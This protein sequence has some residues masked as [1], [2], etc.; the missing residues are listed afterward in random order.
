MIT[1]QNKT[2]K[3]GSSGYVCKTVSLIITNY[4]NGSLLEANKLGIIWC[5]S[6]SLTNGCFSSIPAGDLIPVA[7]D[8]G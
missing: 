2:G 5:K 4:I 3:R 6:P 7:S 8:N 1:Y